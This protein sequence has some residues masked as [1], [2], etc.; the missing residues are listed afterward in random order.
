MN[1]CGQLHEN[2]F[3]KQ[4]KKGKFSNSWKKTLFVT[5]IQ[6]EFLICSFVYCM[7]LQKWKGGGGKSMI[8]PFII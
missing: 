2:H 7:L 3:D 8:F 5:S 1:V 4:V 6:L